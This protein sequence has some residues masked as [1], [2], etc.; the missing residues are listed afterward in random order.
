MS[1]LDD[2]V[3]NPPPQQQ[4]QQGT[5]LLDSAVTPDASKLS[6]SAQYGSQKNPDEA[7]KNLQIQD[8]T[9]G[10]VPMDLIERNSDL[11]SKTL[12]DKKF[13]ATTYQKQSPVAASYLSKD[14]NNYAAA[15]DDLQNIAVP[16]KAAKNFG[17]A[18]NLVSSFISGFPKAAADI[19]RTPAFLMDLAG[20]EDPRGITA[21]LGF[22][23]PNWMM[24]NSAT[25]YLD[26]KSE[27]FSN[28]A[29]TEDFF[30]AVSDKRY[31]DAGLHIANQIV[32][33]FPQ[34]LPAVFGPEALI[35]S[36]GMLGGSEAHAKAISEGAEPAKAADLGVVQGGIA[37]I[38]M[39]TGSMPIL[40]K[41]ASDLVPKIGMEATSQILKSA[42]LNL[43]KSGATVGAQG[44]AQSWANDFSEYAL[45]TN[46]RAMDGWLKRAEEGGI[47]G[48]GTGFALES[49]P[50]IRD[51]L[52]EH[53][54]NVNS[55][56]YKSIGDAAANSTLLERHPAGFK[57][58]T[59][60][61]VDGTG[62]DNIHIPVASWDEY[63]IKKGI[64]PAAAAAELGHSR[65]YD[66]ARSQRIDFKIPTEDLVSKMAKT[67]H[68][69]G[70][71]DDI[72]FHPA[73]ATVNDLKE[74]EPKESPAPPKDETLL[75]K[76]KANF[77]KGLGI[78][79]PEAPKVPEKGPM[80]INDNVHSDLNKQVGEIAK[81]DEP[82]DLKHFGDEPFSMSFMDKNGNE[83]IH[84]SEGVSDEELNSIQGGVKNVSEVGSIQ[85]SEGKNEKQ[86]PVIR[87]SEPS[88]PTGADESRSATYADGTPHP[89]TRDKDAEGNWESDESY[90]KRVL[91]AE[92]RVAKRESSKQGIR[93]KYNDL[94]SKAEPIKP[95]TPEEIEAGKNKRFQR[96]ETEDEKRDRATLAALAEG[97][98]F[99]GDLGT[100]MDDIDA[101][102]SGNKVFH[103]LPDGVG[104]E[105]Q[106]KGFGNGTRDNSRVQRQI[107]IPGV[108]SI[109]EQNFS[110]DGTP[111]SASDHARAIAEKAVKEAYENQPRKFI[112]P[113]YESLKEAHQSAVNDVYSKIMD[114]LRRKN[115]KEWKD[116][117]DS[118]RKDLSQ[119]IDARPE[120]IA[121]SVLTKG[122]LPDGSKVPG[123]LE[124]LKINKD[125]LKQLVGDLKGVPKIYED[126]GLPPD[127]VSGIFGYKTPSDMIEAIKNADNRND[128][129]EMAVQN[130][131]QDI[132]GDF[133]P[134]KDA[135]LD[136]IRAIHNEKQSEI[137]HKELQYMASNHLKDLTDITKTISKR[138]PSVAEVK[139]SAEKIIGNKSIIETKPSLYQ[140]AE[141]RENRNA[142]NLWGKGDFKGA[143]D[144]KNRELLN[145]ELFNAAMD[146]KKES[147]KIVVNLKKFSK[148]SVR[149][150]VMKAGHTYMDQIDQL[151]DRYNLSK[152][153]SL[154]K[155]AKRES[156]LNFFNEQSKGGQDLQIPQ[157]LMDEANQKNYKEVPLNELRD[158]ND[159]VNEINRLASL[160]NKLFGNGKERELDND[161]AELVAAKE[162]NFGDKKE[163][164]FDLAPSLKKQLKITADKG[165]GV[166]TKL[167]FLFKKLDGEKANGP[168]WNKFFKPTAMAEDA[169]NEFKKESAKSVSDIFDA[170]SSRKDRA[171]WYF[172]PKFIPELK[173]DVIDGNFSEANL[174][175]VR[176][177][178]GNEYNRS[179]MME[180]NHWNENHL[181]IIS[182]MSSEK[183][184]KLA[185]DVWS[186]LETYKPKIKNML[187]RMHGIKPEWVE[188]TPFKVKTSDGKTMNLK[189]G[190]YPI[191]FEGQR[192]E[193]T[194]QLDEQSNVQDMMGGQWARAMTK[195]GHLKERVGTGGKPLKLDL[196]VLT[197]HISNVIH[198]ITHRET[199]TDIHKLAND[200]EIK[201]N[202]IDAVGREAYKQINPWI[203]AIAGEKDY[204]PLNY[205]ESTARS[206]RMGATA[207]NIG[208]KLTS[209]LVHN[210]GMMTAAHEL[211][212]EYLTKGLNAYF[213]H[214][215]DM[216][217]NWKFITDRSK[218][219]GD[220][221]EMGTMDR[222]LKDMQKHLHGTGFGGA[223]S[224]LT[225][226]YTHDFTKYY[227][228]FIQ[229]VDK[230]NCAGIWMGAYKKAM[231][232]KV[233]NI[234]MG[235]E[236][237]AIDYA[238]SIV[239]MTKGSGAMK[240][241]SQIQRGNELQKLA[242]M[243]YTP[244][245]TMFNQYARSINQAKLT[246]NVPQMIS[247]LT[248]LVA[249]P[250]VGQ[251]LIRG[252][253]PDEDDSKIG[254]IARQIGEYPAESIVG[255]RDL[256]HA[257]DSYLRFGKTDFQA[258][259]AF[260]AI[261][262]ALQSL[263]VP[264]KMITG[265]DV[266]QEDVKNAALTAGYMFHLPMRQIYQTLEYFKEWAAG[267]QQPGSVPEGVWR[268]LVTGKKD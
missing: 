161:R 137:L 193:R 13:D 1:L 169:E 194:R 153:F 244:M 218:M 256:V 265:E 186:H 88:S 212:A 97:L 79:E 102:I 76:I 163:P 170:H 162:A 213:G 147:D 133:D 23:A 235:H 183:D 115:T 172:K 47:T 182:A 216:D 46:P 73:D 173:T 229:F 203:A 54:T 59:K 39:A 95:P 28:K 127:L 250:A 108:G 118:L 188:P 80:D 6:T 26:K 143:Y 211:G 267:E 34:L 255:V 141:I 230:L 199:I 204:Q 228:M 66:D 179:A 105:D 144:A 69:A 131:M 58:I 135:P 78:K 60:G 122:T 263:A 243:F 92:A 17:V 70:L 129:V 164:P 238:D 177:N 210:L 261:S 254:W 100:V 83:T 237:N 35:G 2:A 67:E 125:E 57:E 104:N 38:M 42:G 262:T 87:W 198:D 247:A 16:E 160:K 174:H 99:G 41:W 151:T 220:R 25:D 146:A 208:F 81:S 98:H 74:A 251:A 180:G 252:N 30:S 62:M 219:M 187:E 217:K 201:Q 257:G 246:K 185:Q 206:L 113:Q 77:K 117:E 24:N 245:A 61:A 3:T 8:K 209:G 171:M 52:K 84:H 138:P 140:Q 68:Y 139:D 176:L 268:A 50:A 130:A 112:L 157:S 264:K 168:F 119:E 65:S 110:S 192:S 107:T 249:L 55:A 191:S 240:D 149:E 154:A 178:M 155:M 9:S 85:G 103:S 91:A 5:S 45:G 132:H 48:A 239:R 40:K 227:P 152:N 22:K 32:S 215:L 49:F 260:E 15:K 20:D 93:L 223:V 106:N 31:G 43:M 197:N 190:Y 184:W 226:A 234:D 21:P 207:V 225:N 14:P 242:T 165:I 195:Q 116:Q 259:P 44:F 196:S 18:G 175:A 150:R 90:K 89:I 101:R 75:G 124:S 166:H 232:G 158:V 53:Q 156:L 82:V 109:P 189:G 181:N 29:L 221:F 96:P 71:K 200:S 222:D 236:G 7:A 159:T 111:T 231:D 233:E 136:A 64:D 120:Q 126:G 224:D 56:T 12:D 142:F 121:K 241:L 4:P 123:A 51:A 248:L 253:G 27:Q 214:P 10:K 202:I 148:K 63:M 167:E 19:L 33:G 145:H 94:L 36:S 205:L 258:S 37:S 72:R 134:F 128:L 266:E 114:K 86:R 11:L